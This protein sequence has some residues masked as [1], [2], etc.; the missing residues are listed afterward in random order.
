MDLGDR[1]YLAAQA[2]ADFD[3]TDGTDGVESNTGEL[4]TLLGQEVTV[5]LDEGTNLVRKLNEMTYRLDRQE[6][7]GVLRLS[8]IRDRTDGD[9]VFT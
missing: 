6:S 2:L 5:V 1:S 4:E 7:T 9:P 3:G 8:A